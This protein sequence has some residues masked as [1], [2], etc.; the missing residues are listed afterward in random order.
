MSL[1]LLFESLGLFGRQFFF[2]SSF[3]FFHLDGPNDAWYAG[4]TS[5]MTCAVWVG[6][7]RDEVII[8]NGSGSSL[9]LP[10]WADIMKAADRLPGYQNSDIAPGRALLV[11]PAVDDI[12]EAIEIDITAHGGYCDG[13]FSL[14][15][16]H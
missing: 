12:P 16:S 4:Y 13:H 15:Y 2:F 8:R 14:S 1:L 11:R 3:P 5:A 7:D 9:A 10:I 6:M